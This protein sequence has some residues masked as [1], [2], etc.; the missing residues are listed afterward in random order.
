MKKKDLTKIFTDEIYSC[1]PT[2]HYPTNGIVYNH[3]DQ[4]WGIAHV[5]DYKTSN[6]KGFRYIFIII[7]ILSKHLWTIPLKK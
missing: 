6:K 5:S 4:I 7:D 1:P 2:K 3:I